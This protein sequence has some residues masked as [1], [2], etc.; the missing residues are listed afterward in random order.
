MSNWSEWAVQ[1]Y[2]WSDPETGVEDTLW[3]VMCPHPNGIDP[4]YRVARYGD[5]AAAIEHART[6]QTPPGYG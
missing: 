2:A 5:E 1:P 3:D 4:P 6:H